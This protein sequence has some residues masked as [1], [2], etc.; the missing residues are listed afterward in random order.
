MI[1][2]DMR[3]Y[4]FYTYGEPDEYGQRTLIKDE[5][6]APLVQGTVKMAINTTSQ[7]IQENIK[8]KG[9]SYIGLTQA[10][11]NDTYIIDYKE[12]GLLKVLYV[13]PRGRYKQVF[14]ASYE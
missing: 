14:L 12:E 3:E 7:S 6:G 13:N 1:N 10:K 2:T 11:V 4:N 9:A 8:Y 5:Q